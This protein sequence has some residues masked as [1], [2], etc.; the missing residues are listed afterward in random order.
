[1]NIVKDYIEKN[2]LGSSLYCLLTKEEFEKIEEY[3]GIKLT[4]KFKS[5]IN[6]LARV[7]IKYSD[8]IEFC[9]TCNY[10]NSSESSTIETGGRNICVINNPIPELENIN[11][12]KGYL[13][14]L[15]EN[16]GINENLYPIFDEFGDRNSLICISSDGKV[17]NY[18]YELDNKGSGILLANSLDEFVDKLYLK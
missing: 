3:I 4:K 6:S 18:V 1:M 13:S 9:I 17:Y 11:E 14:N 12:Y 7:N 16:T 10:I 2:S 5:L 15:R 8:N